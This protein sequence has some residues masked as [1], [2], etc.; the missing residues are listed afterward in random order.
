MTQ[1]AHIPEPPDQPDPHIRPFAAVLQEIDH[2]HVH[3][4]L[5]AALRDLVDAVKDTGKKGTLGLTITVKPI[6]PGQVDI[7]DIV[8][9]VKLDAPKPTP[10]ST[11]FFTDRTG[12]LTREDPNGQQLQLPLRVVENKEIPLR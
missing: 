11:M 10:P 2:G 6:K 9:D 5:S 1:P 12:N 3:T 7:L 4:N 8:A